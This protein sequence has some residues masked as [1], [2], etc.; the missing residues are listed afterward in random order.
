MAV[1]W[2][3]WANPTNQMKPE[4]VLCAAIHY[5]DG[6]ERPHPPRNLTTGLCASGWRHHNCFTVLNAAL[7]NRDKIGREVQGFLTSK[8]RFIDRKEAGQLAFDSGQIEEVSARLFS[9]DVW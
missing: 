5:D 4:Y 6:I 1:R 3:T 2:C 9:E 8:G 7:P